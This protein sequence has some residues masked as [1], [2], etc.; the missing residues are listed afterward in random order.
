MNEIETKLQQSNGLRLLAA[1]FYEPDPTLFEEEKMCR[2]ISAI[3]AD[4]CPQACAAA[5]DMYLALQNSSLQDLQ[6]AHAELFLGPFELKA[7]PYGSTYLEKARRIMGD[8]TMQVVQLY[9]KAGLEVDIKEPPDHIVIELEF[10]SYLF[11]L[12]TEALQN[13]ESTQVAKLRAEQKV[14]QERYLLPWMPEFIENMKKGTENNFYLALADCLEKF[15]CQLTVPDQSIPTY[16]CNG[17]QKYAAA[18]AY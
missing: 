1:C 13:S 8:S 18:T 10:L 3:C 16:E 12:E 9:R 11:A 2:N 4:I 17:T 7:S 15:L 5:S 14:F 6:I